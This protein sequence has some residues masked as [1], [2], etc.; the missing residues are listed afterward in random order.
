MNKPLKELVSRIKSD[1]FVF[2][3]TDLKKIGKDKFRIVDTDTKNLL[4]SFLRPRE[5]S[6]SW[7]S[8]S[9]LGFPNRYNLDIT[10]EGDYWI[11]IYKKKSPLTPEKVKDDTLSLFWNECDFIPERLLEY[12]L[13]KRGID[14]ERINASK[15]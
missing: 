12:N 4:H 9:N 13:G 5:N 3:E 10:G 1:H 7:L 14:R 6:L 2:K 15:K 8:F 11:R